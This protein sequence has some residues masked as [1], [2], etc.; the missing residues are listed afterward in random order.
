M[1]SGD[2][3]FFKNNATNTIVVK[4]GSTIKDIVIKNNTHDV[5]IE[6]TLNKEI[7]ER[8]LTEKQILLLI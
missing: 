5:S 6:I 7:D 2:D 3:E 4:E 8:I 1:F